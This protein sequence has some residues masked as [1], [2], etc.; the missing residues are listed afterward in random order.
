MDVRAA[1]AAAAV[2]RH[3][4]CPARRPPEI[5]VRYVADR[6]GP[7]QGINP[8]QHPQAGISRCFNLQAACF[9]NFELNL[10]G[11]E[12]PYLE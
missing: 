2:E 8:S 7:L 5:S 1:A 3:G 9:F 6:H 11:D 4:R 10:C 12:T